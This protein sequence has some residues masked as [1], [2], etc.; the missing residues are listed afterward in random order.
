MRNKTL[1]FM[2]ET[3]PFYN[4]KFLSLNQQEK[5]LLVQ[6]IPFLVIISAIFRLLSV[7]KSSD[8]YAEYWSNSILFLSIIFFFILALFLFIG[9]FKRKKFGWLL[10]CF[11]QSIL[12]MY[13]FSTGNIFT[14]ILTSILGFWLLMQV[15]GEYR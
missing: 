15:R 1:S 10:V 6:I 9:L 5:E 4:K 7:S 3:K 8:F 2:K 12:L 14:G 13:D 11:F